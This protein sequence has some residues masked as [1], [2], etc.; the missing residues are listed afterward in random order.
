MRRRS[1]FT[2][3]LLLAGLLTGCG[4]ADYEKRM[5]RQRHR[6]QVVDEEQKYLGEMVEPPASENTD[7]PKL[8]PFE[9]FLRLPQGISRTIADKEGAYAIGDLIIYRYPGPDGFNVFLAAG[10]A[11]DPK[12]DSRK[13]EISAEEFRDTFVLG[14]STI[15]R[16]KKVRRPAKMETLSRPAL[17]YT[18]D[19]VRG[20]DFDMFVLEPDP[21]VPGPAHVGVYVHQR[22]P[23]LLGLA[24]QV[25][26][27][28]KS[29]IPVAQGIDLSL[30]SLDL[31]DTAA[32]KREAF[33]NY[34]RID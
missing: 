9:V 26:Y 3:P 6:L 11:R 30:R 16:D 29:D 13:G 24:Y 14:V 8:I 4:I 25:P 19:K 31:G 15:L 18:K 28:R 23:R 5:D 22:G 21:N 17:T 7:A 27:E 1:H 20:L 33:A 34:R 10:N 2:W 32:A 12:S